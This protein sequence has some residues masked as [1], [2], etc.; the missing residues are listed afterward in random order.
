MSGKINEKK[1]KWTSAQR[2]AYARRKKRLHSTSQHHDIPQWLVN[3]GK[4]EVEF[5]HCL[6]TYCNDPTNKNL[7]G[8]TL[9]CRFLQITHGNYAE[10]AYNELVGLFFNH[11]PPEKTQPVY[12][13][14]EQLGLYQKWLNGEFKI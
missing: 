3:W 1:P 9:A 2:K 8:V 7:F 12:D 5:K 10:T 11:L 6:E 13:W 4:A 14:K